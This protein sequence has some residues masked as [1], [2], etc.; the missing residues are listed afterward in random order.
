LEGEAGA[1]DTQPGFRLPPYT[2]EEVVCVIEL[3][4]DFEFPNTIPFSRR[5]EYE[6]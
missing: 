1:R 3:I 2:P 6:N 4:N 5:E